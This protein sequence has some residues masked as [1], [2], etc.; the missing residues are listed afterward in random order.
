MDFDAWLKANGYDA[1]SLDAKMRKHLEAAYKAET[2]PP[3]APPVPTPAMAPVVGDGGYEAELQAIRRQNARIEAINEIAA[4]ACRSHVASRD[5]IERFEA[6][7][8]TAVTDHW[9]LERFQL[10]MLREERSV[11]PML[12]APKAQQVTDEVVEAAMC[13]TEKLPD[14]EKHFSEQTLTQAQSSFRHGLGLRDAIFL[15]AE[16]NGNY[17]GSVRD[18]KPLLRAAFQGG[19]D[20]AHYGMRAEGPSTLAISGILSNVANKFLRVA[21]M[22]VESSWRKI[23]TIKPAVDFKTMTTYSLTGDN[24]Y[25]EVAPGGEI[26]SGTLGNTSYTNQAKTYAKLLGIDRR[27]IINDDLGA[28]TGA[29]K[30]LGRGGALKLNSVFWTEWLADTAFFPTDKSF[31]NYD[32]GA[33]DSVLSLA[34]L[35]NADTIFR[36]QT[37]P[38]GK[39][40]AAIPRILLVPTALRTVGWNLLNSQFVNLVTASTATQGTANP[41]MSQFELVDSIYLAAA[42]GGSDTAWYLLASP[43]DISA[44]EVCFLNGAEMPTIETGEIDIDR[45]GISM[46]GYH[47]F[48]AAKQEYRA[49]VKLKGAA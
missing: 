38:D 22:N 9:S 32:D 47:D 19:G 8:A 24:T 31:N 6:L 43:D 5:K 14:I 4:S 13:A 15:A 23:A 28:L 2:A 12:L 39:P 1:A 16:R 11:G 36:A 49:G 25:D 35:V 37:D 44:I 17:R 21:F 29:G 34:G 30:R 10:A 45:L 26:K 27:D 46:R 48:G 20:G 18:L 3:P 7:R 42:N 40:L 41:W 33:T